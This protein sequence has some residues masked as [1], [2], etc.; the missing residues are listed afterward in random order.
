M[1]HAIYLQ[2][3][4]IFTSVLL[5]LFLETDKALANYR[6]LFLVLTNRGQLNI[7][8]DLSRLQRSLQG[9]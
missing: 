7:S 3:I 4:E 8:S 2:E 1:K 5:A 6:A 9:F